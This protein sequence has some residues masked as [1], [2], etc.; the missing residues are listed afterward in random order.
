MPRWTQEEYA[1]FEARRS[2]SRA[3]PKPAVRDESVAEAERKAENT[4][5]VRIRITGYRSRLL[6]PDNFCPKYFVDCCKYAGF[7]EDDSADH[8]T[9]ETRQVKVAS[10]SKERTE[11]EFT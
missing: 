5:R 9:I 1:A 3:E 7:I 10:K 6:D 4:N 11:I 2:S 8:I